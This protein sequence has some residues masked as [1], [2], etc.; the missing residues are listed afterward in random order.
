MDQ[1]GLSCV[2][3]ASRADEEPDL[4]SVIVPA[5]NAERFIRRTLESI[6]RQSYKHLEIIA[7]DDGSQD[8]T[9]SLV[10]EAARRDN[11]IRLV[12]QDNAGAAA[13]RNRGLAESRGRFIAPIDADDLWHR[14]KVALQVDTL[15]RAPPTVGVAYCWSLAIDEHDRIKSEDPVP[16]ACQFEG[17]VFAELAVQN[18]VG[19][20]SVPLIRRSLLCEIGGYDPDRRIQPSADWKLYLALAECGDYALVR[21]ALVGYRQMSGSMSS[22]V[23]SMETSWKAVADWIRER[24]PR[25]PRKVIRR[26]RYYGYAYLLQLALRRRAPAA[27]L[28]CMMV[29]MVNDPIRSCFLLLALL[30]SASARLSRRRAVQGTVTFDGPPDQRTNP[31]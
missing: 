31:A 21:Q 12:R 7:V 27:A 1:N 8:G 22:A 6:S 17:K 29:A 19:N 14:D 23:N 28:R 30:K 24:N 16:F 11:R 9:A 2:D 26:Q 25:L 20:G 13:A 18:F 10:A 3:M 5:Y 15:R 4:V